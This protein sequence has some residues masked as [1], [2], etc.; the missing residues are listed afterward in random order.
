MKQTQHKKNILK[1]YASITLSIQKFLSNNIKPL[2]QTKFYVPI[3]LLITLLFMISRH[4]F[5]Y[6]EGLTLNIVLQIFGGFIATLFGVYLS[7]HLTNKEEYMRKQADSLQKLINA[8]LLISDDISFKKFNYE[9][10]KKVLDKNQPNSYLI[11]DDFAFIQPILKGID[12]QIFF[13]IVASGDFLE[14]SKNDT[15]TYNIQ[16]AYS[17]TTYC[18]TKLINEWEYFDDRF[19]SEWNKAPRKEEVKSLQE[20]KAYIKKDLEIL[21]N[22]ILQYT[23]VLNSIERFLKNHDFTSYNRKI[24]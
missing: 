2:H 20:S 16:L 6:G 12:N 8:L 9:I 1:Y 5:I 23:V 13:S 18:S 19:K 3:I 7:L 22:L 17:N 14:I 10:I 4:F 11:R 21:N 24:R 15:L